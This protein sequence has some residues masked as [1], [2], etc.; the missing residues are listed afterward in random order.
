MSSAHLPSLAP[1]ARLNSVN[2]TLEMQGDIFEE[3]T[4]ALRDRVIEFLRFVKVPG[5]PMSHSTV[6]WSGDI[7]G[8]IRQ[9]TQDFSHSEIY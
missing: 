4:L 6:Y 9:N 8:L 3:V 7:Q 1:G 2:L 5:L